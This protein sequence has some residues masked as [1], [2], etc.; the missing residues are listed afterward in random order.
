M[1][2]RTIKTDLLCGLSLLFF[3]TSL[4]YDPGFIDKYNPPKALYFISITFLALLFIGANT[5]IKRTSRKVELNLADL[6]F[7]VF[8]LFYI[9]PFLFQGDF[10][11]SFDR[12]FFLRLSL[13]GF[14]FI[15]KN[16][17]NELPAEKRDKFILVFILGII[18][19]AF[20]QDLVAIK[21]I[22]SHDIP[23][24]AFDNSGPYANFLAII[25]IL[26]SGS[27]LSNVF[28]KKW[29]VR[30]ILFFIFLSLFIL[31]YA[32]ART[33]WVALPV[34]V[35]LLLF[36]NYHSV[37]RKLYFRH[38]KNSIV[39][40]AFLLAV[41]SIT[42]WYM[43][44]MKK[45]SA[46]GRILI[47]KTTF[48][49]ISE[50]PLFGHGPEGFQVARGQAQ[51]NYFVKHWD[52][53]HEKILAD[54]LKFAFNDYLQITAE[55]GIAGFLLFFLLLILAFNVPTKDKMIVLIKTGLAV[56]FITSLFHIRCSEFQQ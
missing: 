29:I 15:I 52:Y 49:A 11:G 36:Q 14:Y 2:S 43:Y 47:W 8:N 24:G 22:L 5:I 44:Q 1:I 17:Y 53:E 56:L 9:I 31:I 21:Q 19:I 20:I 32:K 4:I 27:L 37:I 55:T 34:G 23:K 35:L 38:K 48:A 46:D 3:F 16:L 54:D 42:G 28:T 6:I 10:W 39:V 7:I 12:N 25:V 26:A 33:A 41:V 18:I 45:D 40:L 50:K 13:L 30:F 51:V